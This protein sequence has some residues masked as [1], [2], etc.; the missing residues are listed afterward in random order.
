MENVPQLLG[1]PEHHAIVERATKMGFVT[2]GAV[3][4]AADYGVPQTRYRAFIVGALGQDP[5]SFFPPI[6]THRQP[7][8]VAHRRLFNGNNVPYAPNTDAWRTVRDAIADLH[9]PEGTNVREI[10]A[11][12]DLHFGR[13]PTATSRRR[14]RAVPEGGN[15]FDLQRKA[16]Q[17]TPGCWIRKTSGGTDLFGRLW[18]DRPA[19]T[20]RTEFFKPEKGRYLHPSQHRPITHREAARLQTFP[21]DFRF[22]G[23]KVEIA[24]QIGNAVPPVLAARLADVVLALL[25]ARGR[26]TRT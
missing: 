22:L 2:S 24:K 10:P 8:P 5:S 21:D 3:L 12:Y 19:V 7:E 20:M 1:S 11:P 23:A 4:C 25:L 26:P 13:T 14:Y 16:P 9:E 17:L 18:W 6:R 15:R